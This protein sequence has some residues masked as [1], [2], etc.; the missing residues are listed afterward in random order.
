M[1]TE[2]QHKPVTKIQKFYS[3]QMGEWRQ[4]WA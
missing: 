3:T 1:A 4:S 2:G